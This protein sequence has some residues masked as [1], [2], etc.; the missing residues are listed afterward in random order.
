[1][2]RAMRWADR[3]PGRAA[4]DAWGAYAPALGVY[5][6]ALILVPIPL[7]LLLLGDEGQA[8]SG[9]YLLILAM[10]DGGNLLAAKAGRTAHGPGAA[11]GP[12]ARPGRR[13]RPSA[14]SGG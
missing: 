3:R 2:A 7:Y 13:D 6:L 8:L 5:S 4:A 12:A 10:W 11:D 14:R 9:R 1:M